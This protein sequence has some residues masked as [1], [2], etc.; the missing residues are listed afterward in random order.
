[1]TKLSLYFANTDP[2][3]EN[4]GYKTNKLFRAVRTDFILLGFHI[5]SFCWVETIRFIL[6]VALK[7]F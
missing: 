5:K 7:Q 3:N 2:S 1:M 4:K 6:F